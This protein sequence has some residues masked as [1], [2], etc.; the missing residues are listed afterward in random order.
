MSV[1]KGDVVIVQIGGVTVGALV[2]NGH[3][4]LA[5]MLDKSN[6]DTPG[7]KQY[8]AGE[9]G[10]SFTLESLFDPDASEG[11]SEALG[12]LKAGTQLTV[13]HGITGTSVQSGYGLI[14]NIELSGPKNEISSY[15]L[16][17]QGTGSVST[18]FGPELHTDANAASDPN[19]NEA[20]ATTGWTPGLLSGTGANVFES[21]GSVKDVGSYA[22]HAD[23]N[24]TPS[25]LARFANTFTVEDG[26]TYNIR[27]SWRHIGTGGNWNFALLDNA[28]TSF[29]TP[30]SNTDTTFVSVSINHVADGTSLECR[31]LEYGGDNDGGIYMDNFSIRKVL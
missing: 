24:D 5:D 27:F 19:G 18:G 14:S 11:V 17:I 9:T 2:S 4:Q 8:D 21:Q 26:A 28:G 1:Q 30:I 13:T 20:D 31:F 7:V 10:W 15:S 16:E 6:K 29:Y 12:Y 22:L 23:A 25:N 3:N